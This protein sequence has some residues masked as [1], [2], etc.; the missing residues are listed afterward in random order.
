MSAEREGEEAGGAGRTAW[1]PPRHFPN[2][3]P[4]G[5]KQGGGRVQLPSLKS[6]PCGW[7]EDRRDGGA[8]MLSVDTGGEGR[9]KV[10]AVDGFQIYFGDRTQH[11]METFTPRTGERK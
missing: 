1:G 4:R 10:L 8:R 9:A 11:W 2:S 5:L 6:N 7:L 3:S